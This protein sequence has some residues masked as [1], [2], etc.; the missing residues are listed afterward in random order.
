MTNDDERAK[1]KGGK[2]QELFVEPGPLA[3]AFYEGRSPDDN[4]APEI[5]SDKKHSISG[6]LPWSP[7]NAQEILEPARDTKFTFK[8]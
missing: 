6:E 2:L 1:S 3:K 5:S 7:K 4:A 8:K